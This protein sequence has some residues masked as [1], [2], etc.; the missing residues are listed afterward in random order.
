MKESM[1]SLIQKLNNLQIHQTKSEWEDNIPDDIYRE[2]FFGN[3]ETIDS[4]IDVD[5]H[6][7]YE[8]SIEVLKF[9]EGLLGVRYI[10]NMFSESQDYEDCYHHLQF[11]E[12]EEFTT[13]TYRAKNN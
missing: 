1:T 7:W 9:E 11:F 2:Y 10:T 3:Y 4:N 12:M 13:I 6:R 5:T 8:T